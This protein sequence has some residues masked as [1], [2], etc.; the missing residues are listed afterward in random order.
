MDLDS[1]QVIFDSV[2]LYLSSLSKCIKSLISHLNSSSDLIKFQEHLENT[3]I[4]YGF[5]PYSPLNYLIHD[6]FSKLVSLELFL[7]L[8]HVYSMIAWIRL[9]K[10]IRCTP[11]GNA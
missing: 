11:H 1:N 2:D 4:L 3:L 6:Y 8:I 5:D 10:Y 7:T 9:I